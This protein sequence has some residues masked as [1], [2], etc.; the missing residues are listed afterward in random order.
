MMI[1]SGTLFIVVSIILVWRVY[2]HGNNFPDMKYHFDSIAIKM[3]LILACIFSF[4][5]LKG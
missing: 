4:Y 3:A 1:L 2:Q 5:F